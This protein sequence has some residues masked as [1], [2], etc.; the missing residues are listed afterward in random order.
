MTLLR[1]PLAALPW[2]WSEQRTLVVAVII[3]AALSDGLDGFLARLRE[4]H[5]FREPSRRIGV[6]LDP[7]CDKVFVASTLAAVG[8][9]Y[10]VPVWILALLLAREMVL[11]LSVLFRWAV[12][13]RRRKA[14]ATGRADL[15]GK[16]TTALQFGCLVLLVLGHPAAVPLA[17]AT[18]LVG[19][20]AGFHYVRRMPF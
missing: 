6:W 2:L 16:T 10:A 12:P 11:A 15:M 19:L 17:A 5:L 4:K 13:S 18:G 1:L 20:L 7:L 3:A 14:F 8:Y 9:A